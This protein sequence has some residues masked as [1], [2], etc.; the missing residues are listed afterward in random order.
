M[1]TPVDI[2]NKEFKSGGLGYDKRDVESFVSKLAQDYET[3]YR[4]NMDYK[5]KI[6]NLNSMVSNY[7][8]ME[9][10]L[11][12]ALVLAEKTAEET[13]VAAEKEAKNIEKQANVRAQIMIADAKDEIRHIQE[14][15]LALSRQFDAFKAQ[16]KAILLSN[17]NLLDSDSFKI[18]LESDNIIKADLEILKSFQNEREAKEAAEKAENAENAEEVDSTDALEE[19]KKEEV[20]EEEE[21]SKAKSKKKIE[22]VKIVDEDEE[23]EADASDEDEEDEEDDEA[24]DTE[25]PDDGIDE[26]GEIKGQGAFKFVDA[27]D[28][29]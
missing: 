5:D 26:D 1:L 28:D 8:S 29:D 10:T 13:K 17:L 9:K 7:R 3:L 18:S 19:Q 11:Q 6:K 25:E 21:S 4:E 20:K 15:S 22:P 12:K 16:Y 24:S 27:E 23:E 2:Q 14:K